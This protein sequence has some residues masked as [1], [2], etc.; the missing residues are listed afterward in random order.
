M[1]SKKL[2]MWSALFI[3]VFCIVEAQA[4]IMT[5]EDCGECAGHVVLGLDA[6]SGLLDDPDIDLNEVFADIYGQRDIIV[7]NDAISVASG[8]H[9]IILDKVL[10]DVS[11]Q[12]GVAAFAIAPRAEVNLTLQ[13]ESILISSDGCAGIQV[14]KGAK[15]RIVKESTG[16]VTAWGGKL[17]AGI[18]GGAEQSSGEI[19]IS[20]GT[21]IA[22]THRD[23]D[24]YPACSGI[25]GGI[26]GGYESITITG[27]IVYAEGYSHGIGGECQDTCGE[28][29]ISGGVVYAI[30][31]EY[32]AAIGSHSENHHGVITVAGG[33]VYAINDA[34][35]GISFGCSKGT[36]RFDG[37]TV[38]ANN[39]MLSDDENGELIV[40]EGL[41][42]VNGKVIARTVEY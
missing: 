8:V 34:Y 37:G 36:I 32:G 2:Q 24:Y 28:I 14:P 6:V 22:K 25:G 41:V 40:T 29:E 15:L 7:G 11:N 13:Y 5:I 30:G 23:D 1:V 12:E 20:G 21:V 9:D 18:G 35:E 17:G 26:N 39:G 16:S 19:V 31:G 4:E 10:I 38:Y 33:V 42:T 3:L 27:G